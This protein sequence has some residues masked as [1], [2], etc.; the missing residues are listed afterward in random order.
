MSFG[1]FTAANGGALADDSALVD[2]HGWLAGVRSHFI[3]RKGAGDTV[4]GMFV[5]EHFLCLLTTQKA[6]QG[7]ASQCGDRRV[8]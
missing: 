7:R 6:L 5:S 8:C 2:I 1:K 3:A 4:K